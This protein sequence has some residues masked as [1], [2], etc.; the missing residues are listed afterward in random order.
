MIDGV[1]ESSMIRSEDNEEAWV[2][3]Q[4]IAAPEIIATVYLSQS[5]AVGTAMMKTAVRHDAAI[6]DFFPILFSPSRDASMPRRGVPS[7]SKGGTVEEGG[8][9]QPS[10][11]SGVGNAAESTVFTPFH[12]MKDFERTG[13]E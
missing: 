9:V 2:R 13:T 5:S 12:E 4:N 7:M 3:M 10:A 6:K 8:A 11:A 1:P